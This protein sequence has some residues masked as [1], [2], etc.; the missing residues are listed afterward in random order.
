[1]EI[2]VIVLNGFQEDLKDLFEEMFFCLYVVIFKIYFMMYKE[3][4][5]V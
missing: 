3:W 2:R 5:K 4:G 1:M